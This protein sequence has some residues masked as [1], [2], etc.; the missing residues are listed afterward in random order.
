MINVKQNQIAG[1]IIIAGALI[2]GAILI[3]NPSSTVKSISRELGLNKT[4]FAKCRA[5]EETK[6]A[7]QSNQD[8]GVKAGAKGTP[9]TVLVTKDGKKFVLNGAYPYEEVKKIIDSIL[10]GTAGDGVKID[11]SPV[12]QNDFIKGDLNAEIIA[13]EYSDP[14]CPFSKR[15]HATMQQVMKNY[16]NKVAWVFRYFPLDSIHQKARSESEAIECAGMLKGNEM[17]W[18]YLDRVFELT[19]SNDGL[20]PALL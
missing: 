16:N 4:A 12:V 10:A 2:A 17:F 1:A 19:P 18:K 3:K 5:G 7:V 9:Y 14:E 15:F 13:V 20:D 11:M 8:D 6:K